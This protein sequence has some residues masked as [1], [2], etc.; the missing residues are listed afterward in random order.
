MAHAK[1]NKIY[2][3]LQNIPYDYHYMKIDSTMRG[4][5]TTEIMAADSI[6]K[7]DL[8]VFNPANPN[9]NR[10]VKDGTLYLNGKRLLETEIANDP[11]CTIETDHLISFLKTEFEEPIQFFSLSEIRNHQLKL[12]GS[13]YLTFDVETNTDMKNVIETVLASEKKVLAPPDAQSPTQ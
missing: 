8:I 12:N 6:L 13:H 2:S 9:S 10:T 4:N 3:E 5:I 7:P 11:L 1:I